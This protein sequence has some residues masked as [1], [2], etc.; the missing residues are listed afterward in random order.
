MVA[1]IAPPAEHAHAIGDAERRRVG[2]SRSLAARRR[3][4]SAR[5]RPGCALSTRLTM[6]RNSRCCLI[7]VSRPTV[8]IT[9]TSGRQVQRASRAPSRRACRRRQTA[10]DRSRAGRRGTARRGRC[11][12]CPAAR[13]RIAG[14]DGD[15]AIADA[16][17]QALERDEDARRR[18]AEI[19]VEHV[20]M[21][22]VHDARARRRAARQVVGGRRAV[23]RAARPSPC[24]CGRSRGFSVAE[25]PIQPHAACADRR[26]ATADGTGCR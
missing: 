13:A 3:R 5:S 19:P 6:S 12:R 4:R 25:L 11:D 23:G 17:Q 15:D 26:A 9:G 1:Q 14:R 2:A 8:A 16:R 21:I 24:A 20:A 7:A 10:T 18:G 22:G